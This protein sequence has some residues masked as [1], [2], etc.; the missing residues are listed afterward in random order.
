[1][2][3]EVIKEYEY[4]ATE[5]KQSL[6]KLKE[7]L[8]RF[9]LNGKYE[10]VNMLYRLA[11]VKTKYGI[12]KGLFKRQDVPLSVKLEVTVID[13]IEGYI[14]QDFESVI[15]QNGMDDKNWLKTISKYI[16]EAIEGIPKQVLF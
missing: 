12:Y 9:I 10:K 7:E 8:D 5:L 14:L 16:E 15:L 3:N 4:N 6:V 1:M 13:A 2:N 11:I